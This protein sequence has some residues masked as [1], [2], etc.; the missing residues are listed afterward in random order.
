MTPPHVIYFN[1]CID[2]FPFQ[3]A[4]S[5]SP[6][7]VDTA[8][9][10]TISSTMVRLEWT[11]ILELHGNV[12]ANLSLVLFIVL[13]R[14]WK[15]G[16]KMCHRLHSSDMLVSTGCQDTHLSKILVHN[17]IKT[18][19]IETPLLKSV[20]PPLKASGNQQNFTEW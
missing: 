6:S 4:I 3:F 14:I 13:A 1:F 5:V 9:I 15:V 18:Y 16:I 8:D 12:H 7:V 11:K 19:L 2:L 10:P 17:I 20:N